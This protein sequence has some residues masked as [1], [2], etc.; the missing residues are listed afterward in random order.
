LVA[1]SIVRRV[2]EDGPQ[3]ES[4]RI[5]TKTTE[6]NCVTASD[7]LYKLADRA[8]QSEANIARAKEKGQADLQAQVAHARQSSQQHAAELKGNTAAAHANASAWWGAVQDDWNEHIATIRR[9][10]DDKK[11]D[12]DAT[13]AEHRA[14]TAE[15][16]ADAAVDFA[17][18]ALE[19][20]EYA[21]LD[22]ALARLEADE[23]LAAR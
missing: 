12:L 13:R 5:S 4:A 2:D 20:A 9:N 16:D 6:G 15:D 23:V 10:V 3:N 22:A 18:A 7:Q 1:S 21:V 17:Y 14:E 11:A 8:K 19:E